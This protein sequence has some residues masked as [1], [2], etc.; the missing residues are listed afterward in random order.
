MSFESDAGAAP[1]DLAVEGTS[2]EEKTDELLRKLERDYDAFVFANA[3][4]D[5]LPK[6]AQ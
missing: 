1:Y 5:A 4:L 3:S 6:E 2:I